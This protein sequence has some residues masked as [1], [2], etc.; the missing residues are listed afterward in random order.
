M[1]KITIPVDW[2]SEG[3]SGFQLLQFLRPGGD[4]ALPPKVQIQDVVTRD[5]SALGIDVLRRKRGT[6]AGEMPLRKDEFVICSEAFLAKRAEELL[7]QIA[8]LKRPKTLMI[9]E[10]LQEPFFPVMVKDFNQQGGKGKYLIETQAQWDTFYAFIAAYPDPI[11]RFFECQEFIETPS[12][13]YTSYRVMVSA[14]GKIMASGLSY[15]EPKA[16]MGKYTTDRPHFECYVEFDL[17]P[18]DLLTNPKSRFYLGAKRVVSNVAQGGRSIVLDPTE[19]SKP[20]I[21]GDKEILLA[22]GLDP[23]HPSLPE[24]IKIMA[25]KIGVTLGREMDLVVGID[26]IQGAGGNYYLETNGHP[27]LKDYVD[28]HFY[29]D[30]QETLAYQHMIGNVLRDILDS[31]ENR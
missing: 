6:F 5:I 9:Q 28:T 19:R 18:E 13:R 27:G 29:G 24:D 12:D 17:P 8:E 4:V 2:G 25:Q 15:S 16:K 30:I 31:A 3:L 1:T 26:F 14:L 10:F 22:H 20:M 11:A 7:A 21:D 23:E